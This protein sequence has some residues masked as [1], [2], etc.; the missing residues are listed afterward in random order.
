MPFF[1]K[2]L[3]SINLKDAK[4]TDEGVEF[5]L[6]P[7]FSVFLLRLRTSGWISRGCAVTIHA[8]L[9]QHANAFNFYSSA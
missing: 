3:Q 7:S 9:T 2:A 4:Y 5:H 6:L 8:C 1:H